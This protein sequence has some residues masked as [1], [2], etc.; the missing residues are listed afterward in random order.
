MKN[1]LNHLI[2]I[3][4]FLFL[5]VCGALFYIFTH[6]TVDFSPLAHYNPGH[7]SILLDDEGKEWAR[8]AL[9]RREPIPLVQM[10]AHLK[11]AFIAAEDWNFFAHPGISLKGIIRSLLKNLWH[12]KKVQGASTITQQLVKL[13]FFDSQKTFKRK[14]KEQVYALLA[15]RQFS[16]EQ[17]LE[18]YLNH[19]YFGFGIYGVEAAAQRFWSKSANQLTLDESAT[20]AAI[21]RSPGHYNP[22][23]H[24]DAAQGRR[25]II[26]NSMK[27]LDFITEQEYQEAKKNPVIVKGHDNAVLASHLKEMIRIQLEDELGKNILY[28]GGLIIQ[29]TLNVQI[30]ELAQAAFAKHMSELKK[31]ITPN[32]DGA[33]ITLESKTG[34]VKALVGGYDYAS[35]KF[36]RAWQSKR[37]IGSVIKPLIY[38]VAVEQ[39]ASFADT[40]ID[41]PISIEQHNAVWQPNNYNNRFEGSM[42]LAQALVRSNNIISVKTLLAT[43]ITPVVQLARACHLPDPIHPYPSLALGCVD[44]SLKDVAGMFNVF[45][46]H[47]VYV[48]PHFIVWVKDNWGK[49]M[50]KYQYAKEQVISTRIAD[51]VAKVMEQG[52]KRWRKAYNQELVPYDVI[53]KTGTTNDCR[54]CWFAGASP[55]LTTAVYVG[56]DDNRS[57]GDVYPLKSAFPIWL[58]LHTQLK[59]QA[60]CFT[61]DKN[62]KPVLINQWTG[63]QTYATDPE[64]VEIFA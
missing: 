62:L 57:L 24:S 45:T 36:N 52:I 41:E 10:P 28:T 58:E 38:A 37:Q 60:T 11:N 16:K 51:T 14:I 3:F 49:K 48:Q 54:T 55:D 31:T 61:Y 1:Y 46:N 39:G 7:P 23:L 18:T 2:I 26:L 8:F 33:L 64:A 9:D 40:Q 43:G 25:N 30:Q 22:M 44:A 59:P 42:T 4:L 13:L 50:G 56:C 15:E 29:T 35:S 12:R 53:C 32:V 5:A 6:H 19:V 20:L 47:G 21:I 63:R 27:K 17:I 34:Q